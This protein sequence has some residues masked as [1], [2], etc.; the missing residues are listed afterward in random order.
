MMMVDDTRLHHRAMRRDFCGTNGQ[1][2]NLAILHAHHVRIE[3]NRRGGRISL[4]QELQISRLFRLEKI[5]HRFCNGAFFWGF[6]CF[7]INFI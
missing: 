3:W 1:I 4:Q 2:I 5:D 7:S 6:K